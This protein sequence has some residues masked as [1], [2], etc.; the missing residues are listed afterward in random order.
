MAKYSPQDILEGLKLT[1]TAN[2][3]IPIINELKRNPQAYID[4]YRQALAIAIMERSYFHFGVEVMTRTLDDHDVKRLLYFLSGTSHLMGW[5][6]VTTQLTTAS[7]ADLIVRRFNHRGAS[8][9]DIYR[10]VTMSP[11]EVAKGCIMHTSNLVSGGSGSN[12]GNIAKLTLNA[13]RAQMA[14]DIAL[15][16]DH[17]YEGLATYASQLT[18]TAVEI[19]RDRYT[20]EPIDEDSFMYWCT[21]RGDQDVFGF[22]IGTN[23]MRGNEWIAVMPLRSTGSRTH[24]AIDSRTLSYA[25]MLEEVVKDAGSSSPLRIQQ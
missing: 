12:P 22:E 25:E 2:R 18:S 6:E 1:A 7:D 10:T 8:P 13:S 17:P 9:M 11:Y 5:A 20:I 3:R 19:W 14:L 15:L 24:T 23:S 21:P 4:I 16:N